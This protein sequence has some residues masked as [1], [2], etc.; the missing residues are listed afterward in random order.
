MMDVHSQKGQ[1]RLE[2]KQ[3]RKAPFL[4]SEVKHLP[5]GCRSL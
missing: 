4:S 1:R 2:G 5:W 3:E